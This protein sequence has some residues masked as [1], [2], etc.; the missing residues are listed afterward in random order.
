M[1][2]PPFDLDH[3]HTLQLTEEQVVDILAHLALL[4]ATGVAT[5]TAATAAN[6]LSQ[7][8]WGSDALTLE[9]VPVMQAPVE[10]VQ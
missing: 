3:V 5:F 10:G 6:A 4:G 2:S 9:P 1:S 7:A 8:A